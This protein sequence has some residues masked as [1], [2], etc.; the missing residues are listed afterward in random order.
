[1]ASDDDELRELREK[2]RWIVAVVLVA[3][4]FL[5]RLAP[6]VLGDDYEPLSDLGMGSILAAVLVLLGIE[7]VA[8]LLRR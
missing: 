3:G 5:D 8:W 6:V 1:M 7:S 4:I 2:L